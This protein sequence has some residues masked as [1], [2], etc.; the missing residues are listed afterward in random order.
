MWL[1]VH[2]LHWHVQVNLLLI[3]SHGN[4]G[5]MLI[6]TRDSNRNQICIA[7]FVDHLNKI[8]SYIRSHGDS[9]R[10][11]DTNEDKFH[12]IKPVL[13]WSHGDPDFH[14]DTNQEYK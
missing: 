7:M 2:I 6:Q 9:G 4:S 10:H 14:V 13:V 8:C 12:I 3:W 11:D 5:S 1:Y